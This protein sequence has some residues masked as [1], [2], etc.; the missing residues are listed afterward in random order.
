M[1]PGAAPGTTDEILHSSIPYVQS[2][3]LFDEQLYC[4]HK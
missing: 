3:M 2:V 1:T 4:S